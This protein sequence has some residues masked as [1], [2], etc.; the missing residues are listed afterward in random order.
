MIELNETQI[1]FTVPVNIHTPIISFKNKIVS[2]RSQKPFV[3]VF[4]DILGDNDFVIHHIKTLLKTHCVIAI[5]TDYAQPIA[6][7]DI[8]YINLQEKFYIEDTLE[9]VEGVECMY[10]DGWGEDIVH[11]LH[12]RTKIEL[13]SFDS[14]STTKIKNSI[15]VIDFDG[16]GDIL[17]LIPTLKTL[18]SMGYSVEVVTRFPD[19]LKYLPYIQRCVKSLDEVEINSYEK[20]FDISFKLSL[21]E[22]EFCRQHRVKSSAI[23]CGVNPKNLISC[24]P[25]IYLTPEEK[26][27]AR[28]VISDSSQNIVIA[29]TSADN[30]R[31]YPR[32]RRQFLVDTIHSTF[33]GY[34][35]ILIGDTLGDS[36]ELRRKGKTSTFFKYTNCLDL[37]GTTSIREMFAIVESAN[38]VITI[39]SSPLHVAASFFKP[40]IFLPSTIDSEWRAYPETV[41]IEP[42]VS[43]YPCNDR[44]EE[45]V[46]YSHPGWCIGKISPQIILKELKKF[47]EK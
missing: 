4:T 40:T 19:A 31:I 14:I 5:V 33:P 28:N 17:M 13:K 47:V 3:L 24:R 42:P 36:L 15:L 7:E 32:E 45:C 8:V 22:E 29:F 23:L 9:K 16:L 18:H 38:I 30:R 20:V 44:N 35:I 12:R 39:D 25:E 11:E 2:L 41:S 6:S 27:F 43:C 46:N 34:R 26:Q 37:R 1:Q 21:Y 10:G